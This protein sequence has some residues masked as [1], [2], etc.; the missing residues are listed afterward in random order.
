MNKKQREALT[1]LRD[2][3]AAH[4]MKFLVNNDEW[5]HL[6]LTVDIGKENVITLW[7]GMEETE[8]SEILEQVTK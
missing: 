5:G 2:V 3:M 4:N 1:A 7:W 8:L 6:V